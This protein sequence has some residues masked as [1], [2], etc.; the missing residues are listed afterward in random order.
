PTYALRLA[1]VAAEHHINLHAHSVKKL[2]VAGEPGGSVPAT[3][4]RIESAWNASV[5]DHAGATEVGPWGFGFADG[6][7]LYVNESQFLPEFISVESGHPAKEGELAQLVMTTLGRDGAPVIRYRTGDLV[8]P[9]WSKGGNC[10]FVFL[11]GGVIGRADD[12]LI[13]RGMNV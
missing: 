5:Y 9:I 12:M 1:E 13:V 8:R 4:S 3:R 6:G 7:G 10:C 2:I 11:D